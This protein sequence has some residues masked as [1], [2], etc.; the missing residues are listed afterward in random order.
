MATNLFH[1]SFLAALTAPSRKALKLR[2]S[3]YKLKFHFQDSREKSFPHA[4]E[5]LHPQVL[6]NKRL[7]PRKL[8]FIRYRS[9]AGS[10]TTLLT[11]FIE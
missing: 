6:F 2:V 3:F 10:C 9:M 8:R 11:P 4:A 7:D 1:E 5:I